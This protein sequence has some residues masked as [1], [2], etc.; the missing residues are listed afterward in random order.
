VTFWRRAPREVYR[1]YGEDEYLAEDRVN[2]EDEYLAEEAPAAEEAPSACEQHLDDCVGGA[3]R[4]MPSTPVA[5]ATYAHTTHAA[6]IPDI[7]GARRH[8][9]QSARLLGMGLLAGVG[10]GALLLV[11]SHV[12]HRS[13]A[14]PR[15]S[16]SLSDRA[17]ERAQ[18]ARRASTALG[19]SAA[20]TS[21]YGSSG[22]V[23]RRPK[24]GR[25]RVQGPARSRSLSRQRWRAG[26]RPA[27]GRSRQAEAGSLTAQSSWQPISARTPSLPAQAVSATAD[28][29]E[30]E[31]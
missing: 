5:H 8:R 26:R 23:A 25:P 6:P 22:G 24:P 1:V 16:A 19:S 18:G 27:P 9:S 15:S 30:F 14:V 31:R 29:F 17:P 3:D 10:V 21:I 7:G 13:V 28:E 20:N 12:V 11:L 4:A 2:V